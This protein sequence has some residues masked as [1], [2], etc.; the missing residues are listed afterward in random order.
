MHRIA[1]RGRGAL[2]L[3][4]VL[5][6]L[7]GCS[8]PIFRMKVM[9]EGDYSLTS[10]RL[11]PYFEDAEEQAQAFADTE[12]L[13][14]RDAEEH[15]IAVK[16]GK[17]VLLPHFLEGGIYYAEVTYYIDNVYVDQV[18]ESLVDLSEIEKEALVSMSVRCET[19]GVATEP[20]FTF[21]F[22]Y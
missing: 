12:N 15:T 13:L 21:F 19:S 20:T 11:I 9:N 17:E 4:A 8:G 3:V 1:M 10:V 2:V 5:V 16:T 22:E 7:A 6:I 14:P 18:W